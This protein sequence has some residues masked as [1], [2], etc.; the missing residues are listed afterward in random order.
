MAS[1]FSLRG[2]KGSV[3]LLMT[4]FFTFEQYHNRRGVGSSRIRVHNLIK[5]WPEAGLY[6][7]GE[8]PDVMI[9]Q[10]VYMTQ[11]YKF[12]KYFKGLK[13][14]DICDPDWMDG[15]L[16]KQ[17]IDNVDGVTCPTEELARFLRQ[18]TDKPVKV[19]P[20]RHEVPEIAPK[21]HQGNIKRAVWFGYKHNAELMRFAVP[22]LERLGIE[23]LLI[24]NEDPLASRWAN[25]PES[26]MDKYFFMKYN[27]DT[28]MDDLKTADVCILPKGGRP[29]D[30]FKSDNK[31]TL[32]W[33]AGIPV[34]T[35]SDE[36]S[37]MMSA[38]A[39]NKEAQQKYNYA[40]DNFDCK[41]SVKELKDFISEIS[42]KK[43]Q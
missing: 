24:S 11:D 8:N 38:E 27:G 2:I 25:D 19:I 3:R 28:I 23:L 20:D 37:A 34:V 22:T 42:S 14:L 21:Q 15:A 1:R 30:R 43:S 13:I 16:I 32:A 40:I 35:D 10:K 9:F 41:L 29:Q 26:Y 4:R 31:T 7:Y 18:M 6:K 12:H 36:L 5:Y 17:T 33:L 39:R